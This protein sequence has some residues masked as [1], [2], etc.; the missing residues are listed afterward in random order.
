[1]GNRAKTKETR[2]LSVRERLILGQFMRKR[3]VTI[4]GPDVANEL[5]IDR[6]HANKILMR[7]ERKGWVQRGKRGSYIFVPLSSLTAETMPEDPWALAMELFSPCFISGFTAAEHWDLTEQIFNTVVVFSARS[8]RKSVQKVANITFRIHRVPEEE[9]F[10][11]KKIWRN[12]IPIL[13]AD[14]H[15]TLID[16]L[17]K[18]ELGGGGRHALDIAHAYW[19]GGSADPDRVLEY[20]ARLGRGVVFKRLGYTAESWGSVSDDWL[21]ACRKRVSAGISKLDPAGSDK[22][23]ILTR[24]GLRINVPVGEYA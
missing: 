6:P 8:Q 4:T 1:M 11:T 23:T 24:W 9:I 20:A 10:G 12:N 2:G 22:G 5:G 3:R 19:K 18:P 7:L 15:R 16:V 14:P 21:K 17:D 13:M